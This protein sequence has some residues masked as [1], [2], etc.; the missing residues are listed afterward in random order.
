MS[1]RSSSS[2]TGK[3]SSSASRTKNTNPTRR[4]RRFGRWEPMEKRVDCFLKQMSGRQ[5]E[6][7][8]STDSAP[9][10]VSQ[11]SGL[12]C[13]RLFQIKSPSDPF[14]GEEFPNSCACSCSLAAINSSNWDDGLR[15]RIFPIICPRSRN[16]GLLSGDDL[17]WRR[18]FQMIPVSSQQLQL[19]T[20]N[21]EPDV[22]VSLFCSVKRCFGNFTLPNEAFAL[23][24]VKTECVQSTVAFRFL[25]KPIL[26]YVSLESVFISEK[27]CEQ[28]FLTRSFKLTWNQHI[29]TS[30][31]W[32]FEV[33]PQWDNVN[34]LNEAQPGWIRIEKWTVPVNAAGGDMGCFSH[35]DQ[36]LAAKVLKL[37][38]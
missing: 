36:Q 28:C 16:I 9:F 23:S 11:S 19:K 15:V 27:V 8:V 3:E 25:D 31:W 30:R 12:E 17:R 2:R 33:Q 4:M 1:P 22:H 13:L 5:S 35:L 21:A 20:L 37:K 18:W 24:S 6:E 7:C 14:L 34:I 32:N 38:M 26:L 29:K 10:P